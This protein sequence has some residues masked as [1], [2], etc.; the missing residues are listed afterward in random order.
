MPLPE[1]SRWFVLGALNP[2]G[3]R[4]ASVAEDGTL[5]IYA[6]QIDDLIALA[7]PPDCS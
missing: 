5:R 4:L 2:D 3:R 7:V 6:M 1:R